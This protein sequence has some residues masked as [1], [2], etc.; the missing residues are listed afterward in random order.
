MHCSHFLRFPVPTFHSAIDTVLNI[1]TFQGATPKLSTSQILSLFGDHTPINSSVRIA[2][3]PSNFSGD[4]RI[5]VG[6]NS[7][8]VTYSR[9]TQ[10]TAVT[11]RPGTFA[12]VLEVVEQRKLTSHYGPFRLV[13]Y[14][15]FVTQNYSGSPSAHP[16]LTL[17]LL[18]TAIAQAFVRML[19][20]T[21]TLRSPYT[22]VPT[23][24]DSAL[25]IVST[26]PEHPKKLAGSSFG[27]HAWDDH[28]RSLWEGQ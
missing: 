3:S 22:P 24:D 15:A 2:G 27:G 10:F 11:L 25:A 16:R 20:P 23:S 12:S 26:P 28:N 1:N 21:L 8:I 7:G 13:R 14:H 17:S 19:T 9:T 5:L 18:Y 6:L 4:P